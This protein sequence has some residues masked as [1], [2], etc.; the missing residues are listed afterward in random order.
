MRFARAALLTHDGWTPRRVAT[1]SA[2]SNLEVAAPGVPGASRIV[3]ALPGRAR[4][5]VPTW[6]L[7]VSS[8]KRPTTLPDGQF[9]R[10]IR[11]SSTSRN[12]EPGEPK[13]PSTR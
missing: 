12:T 3:V 6:L 13:T 7:T 1:S 2:L 9:R 11:V 4:R 8:P 10:I 5:S